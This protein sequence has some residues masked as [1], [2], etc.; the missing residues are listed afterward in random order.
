MKWIGEFAI[1]A[2]ALITGEDF[3]RGIVSIIAFM[4]FWEVGSRSESWFGFAFPWVS[5]VPPPT[6]VLHEMLRLI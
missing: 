3:W 2:A 5:Q 6:A 4:A 1:K